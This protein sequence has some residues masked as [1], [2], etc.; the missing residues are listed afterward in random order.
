MTH[1]SFSEDPREPG[2]VPPAENRLDV[3]PPAEE[4]VP[5]WEEEFT[6]SAGSCCDFGED[7]R[8]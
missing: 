5:P 4:E 8:A 3:E 2:S 1:L 7:G 6:L